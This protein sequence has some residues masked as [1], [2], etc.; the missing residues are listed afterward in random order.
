MSHSVKYSPLLR[1][2]TL[3]PPQLC[4]KVCDAANSSSMKGQTLLSKA[5]GAVLC[6]SD[7]LLEDDVPALKAQPW[8]DVAEG[9][10]MEKLLKKCQIRNQLMRECLAE[11]L[12]V[13]VLIVSKFETLF[14]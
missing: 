1:S 9:A 10:G 3:S 7:D 12:G 11:C 14:L 13:Y 5:D 8:P 2:H 4:H 6:G